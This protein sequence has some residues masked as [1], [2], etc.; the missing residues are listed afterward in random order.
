MLNPAFLV[1][2]DIHVYRTHQK[3]GEIILTFPEAYHQGVS[4]GFNIAE[5]V[6]LACPTWLDYGSKAMGIYLNTKEKIPVFPMEWMLIENARKIDELSFDKEPLE[7]LLAAYE[8]YLQKELTERSLVGSHF[9]EIPTYDS[10]IVKFLEDRDNVEEDQY[11]CFYCVN[12]CYASF[13]K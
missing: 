1:E 6:N 10:N 5:A 12:L 9:K 11:E 4:V 8:R 13:V 3:P 2:N 7:E